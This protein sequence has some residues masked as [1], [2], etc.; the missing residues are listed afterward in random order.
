[1]LGACFISFG[2]GWVAWRT[3]SRRW[4]TLAHMATDAMGIGAAFFV[5][6][7]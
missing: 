5:V 3:G 2:Y 1:V 6:G 7:G 4:T